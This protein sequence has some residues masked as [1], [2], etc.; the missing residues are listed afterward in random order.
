MDGTDQNT[1]GTTCR[2]CGT[3]A[4]AG[5]I[6]CAKCGAALKVPSSLIQQA[7]TIPSAHQ[8]A[9]M[10]RLSALAFFSICAVVDFVW[11]CM[12]WH[13]VAAGLVAIVG[14]VP[15]TVVL[16]FVFK[17]FWKGKSDAPRC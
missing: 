2:E 16:Y 12:K 17:A 15:S 7:T 6:F 1:V 14:G 4:D 10:N 9:Q 3:P 13:S 11:G 5:R 8:V